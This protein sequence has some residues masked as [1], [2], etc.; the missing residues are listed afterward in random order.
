MRDLVQVVLATGN[1]GKVRELARPLS[2]LGVDVIG[3]SA[4]PGMGEIEETGSTFEENALIKARTVARRSGL[5]AAADDSGLEVDALGGAPGVRSARYGDD[6]H[7][8]DGETRDARNIRRLLHDLD[9]VEEARR[10]ARFRCCLA[11]VRPE[12]LGGGELVVHGVWEGRILEEGRG[13]NGFGYDPVFLDLESGRSAAELSAE[14]KNARSHRGL[15]VR[16]LVARWAG[17]MNRA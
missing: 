10:T 6:W 8:L 15:A 13:R 1:M 2:A 4:L 16:D 12:E 3:L 7:T 14:E 9:G 17:F 11:V 5:I